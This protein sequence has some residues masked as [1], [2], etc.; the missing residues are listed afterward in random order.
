MISQIKEK[1]DIKIFIL[2]LLKQINYPLEYSIINDIVLQDGFV[3]YMDFVDCFVEL[4]E[5]GSI[6]EVKDESGRELYEITEMGVNIAVGLESR[7]GEMIKE[8]SLKSAVRLIS[9]RE[10]GAK[11]K[12]D[13]DAIDK[14]NFR[15]KC[16]IDDKDGDVFSVSLVVDSK[17]QVEKIRQAFFDHPEA[18]YRAMLAIMT[19]E[20][21][22]LID[23]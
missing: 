17:Y 21:N 1:N 18:M 13:F 19:G 11:L 8:K 4:L 15:V 7:I 5:M 23:D 2:Y 16:G 3:T 12:F 9:F 22:Y 10:R 20:V 6:R 14:G